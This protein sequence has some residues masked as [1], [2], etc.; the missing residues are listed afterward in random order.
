[1]PAL[2]SGL[3]APFASAMGSQLLPAASAITPELRE[4]IEGIE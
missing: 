2:K 4:Q 3:E 1:M